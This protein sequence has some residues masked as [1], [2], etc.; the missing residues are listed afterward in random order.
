MDILIV[1]ENQLNVV[2]CNEFN[3]SYFKLVAY[4]LESERRRGGPNE[5]ALA[6]QAY[7]WALIKC[8][9]HTL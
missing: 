9:G 4:H 2:V 5:R 6:V 3:S 7:L 8:E 1:F